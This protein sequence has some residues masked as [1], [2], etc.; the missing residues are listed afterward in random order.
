MCLLSFTDKETCVS[1]QKQSVQMG[2]ETTNNSFFYS[3]NR[4]YLL[5]LFTYMATSN[6]KLT[7]KVHSQFK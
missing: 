6:T 1:D 3:G 2:T 5:G 7:P 4:K